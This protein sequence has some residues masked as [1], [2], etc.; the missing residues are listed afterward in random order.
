MIQKTQEKIFILSRKYGRK[1]GLDL[2]YFVKNGFWVILRQGVGAITGLALSVA[3]AR[4][5]TQE[6]F[7]QYQFILSILSIVSILSIPGLNTSIIRSAARGCDGDYKEVVR[8]SFI[9]S[10]LGVPALLIIGGYYYIYQS[11]PLGIALMI[12]S[13]FFRFFTLPIPGITFCREKAGSMFQQNTA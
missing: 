12:S 7:G 6:V 8:V 2:P 1:F 10:L 3:F 11:H 9:W 4:L 13:I 5:A